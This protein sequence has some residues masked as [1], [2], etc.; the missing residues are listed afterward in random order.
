MT[1]AHYDEVRQPAMSRL[2]EPSVQCL[3]IELKTAL[4][5]WLAL[6]RQA[7]FSYKYL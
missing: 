3:Q 1:G 6:L 7:Y 4:F 2:L 5:V